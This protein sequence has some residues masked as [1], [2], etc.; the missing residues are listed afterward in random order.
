MATNSLILK[1]RV[2]TVLDAAL[3]FTEKFN[4]EEPYLK[5]NILQRKTSDYFAAQ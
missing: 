4:K 2:I 1:Y 5:Q 3:Y